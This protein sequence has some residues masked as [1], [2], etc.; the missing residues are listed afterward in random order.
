MG[1]FQREQVG[2]CMRK[3]EASSAVSRVT[4]NALKLFINVTDLY[5]QIYVAGTMQRS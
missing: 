5:G 3:L 1:E 4:V 2:L